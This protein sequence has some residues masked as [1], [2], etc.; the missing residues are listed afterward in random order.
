M[1][2]SGLVKQTTRQGGWAQVPN[3]LI[4]PLWALTKI[5][6]RAPNVMMHIVTP[7]SLTNWSLGRMSYQMEL[8]SVI[9]SLLPQWWSGAVPLI[10]LIT[11]SECI[12]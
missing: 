6:V 11:A 4:P 7:K 10:G 8:S 9:C 2:N 12:W 5:L 3:I 1:W